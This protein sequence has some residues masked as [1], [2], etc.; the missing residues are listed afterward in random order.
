MNFTDGHLFM[1]MSIKSHDI[2]WHHYQ[3]TGFIHVLPRGISSVKKCVA[4]RADSASSGHRA[5]TQTNTQINK[6][7][8]RLNLHTHTHMRT[9]RCVTFTWWEVELVQKFEFLCHVSV[10]HP[11][12]RHTNTNKQSNK[13]TNKRFTL[14]LKLDS[15]TTQNIQ[16][17]DSDRV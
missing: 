8:H 12:C 11:T 10:I 13:N 2:T 15:D 16:T 14:T 6:Q 9:S 5:A 4:S 3:L 17:D 7:I 1:L